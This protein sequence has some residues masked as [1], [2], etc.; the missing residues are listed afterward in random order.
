[1][2]F[3][4]TVLPLAAAAGLVGA[5]DCPTPVSRGCQALQ[6]SPLNDSV[7]A[8]GSSVYN[9]ETKEFW[10]NTELMAPG[11]VFRPK[12]SRQLGQA[13]KALVQADAKFAVRGGGHMGIRVS[14]NT[15]QIIQ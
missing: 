10:S 4:S 13:V 5:S 14:F 3:A 6:Q 8:T 9:W 7:F 1:M 11:C 15:L 2:R 12:N